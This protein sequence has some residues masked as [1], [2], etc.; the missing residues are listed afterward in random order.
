LAGHEIGGAVTKSDIFLETLVEQDAGLLKKH[1]IFSQPVFLNNSHGPSIDQNVTRRGL[2]KVGDE[3]TD[4]AFPR[5]AFPNDE[6]YLTCWER[7]RALVEGDAV[8]I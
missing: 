1:N 2:V 4:G 3:A 5:A 7:E 6:G 8:R